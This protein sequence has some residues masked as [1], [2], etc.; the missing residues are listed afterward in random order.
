[1]Q[2]W[3]LSNKDQLIASKVIF[4]QIIENFM[5]KI[6]KPLVTW[7]RMK[8]LDLIMDLNLNLG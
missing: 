5:V 7:I 8:V 2:N 4:F 6:P 1:M 3:V